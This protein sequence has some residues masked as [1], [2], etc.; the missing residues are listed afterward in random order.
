MKPVEDRRP[1]DAGIGENASQPRATIGEGGQHRILG[2][3]GGV[4]VPADQHFDVRVGS[5]DGSENLAAT[6]LR[7][8]IAD[9][10]LQMPL[11]VLQLR[12]KVE[13]KVTPIADATVSG[14]IVAQPV[15]ASPTL[16]VWRRKVSGF[17]PASTGNIC[18]NTSAATR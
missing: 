10:H 13:S 1:G 9:L 15:S 4:E 6:R 16:K 7:F 18:S 8:D 3:P 12:M 14:L 11:P 5:G 2:S 17:L